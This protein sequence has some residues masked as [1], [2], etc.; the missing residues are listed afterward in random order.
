MGTS[1]TQTALAK[2]EE[3][4]ILKR[5]ITE[6]QWSTLCNSLFPGAK[7]SS[8]L[9]VWDYCRARNLDPMKKPCHIVPMKVKDS[10]TGQYDW[11]DVILPG[12]YEHRATAH[13]TG[14]YLGHTKPE[15][16]EMED[17]GE[18]V[19]APTWCE[20]TFY[21]HMKHGR[22]EFPVRVFFAEVVGYNKEGKPNDRWSR[23]PI[24]MLTKCCEAAGLREAFPEE[25]GGEQTAEEIEGQRALDQPCETILPKNGTI[26]LESLAPSESE[27]R[28]HDATQVPPGP[29]A[30]GGE[31]VPPSGDSLT[32][33]KF[34]AATGR[35]DVVIDGSSDLRPTISS[36]GTG[37]DGS[38]GPSALATA[39]QAT[40][41]QSS[42]DKQ[43]PSG[44][45]PTVPA[46]KHSTQI[47]AAVQ[48]AVAKVHK[49]L[50]FHYLNDVWILSG[51]HCIEGF[52]LNPDT[53]KA[54]AA[55]NPDI[56]CFLEILL[57]LGKH[58]TLKLS[59]WLLE[60]NLRWS[61]F[62]AY[63]QKD[64]K[65]LTPKY[66]GAQTVAAIATGNRASILNAITPSEQ[67]LEEVKELF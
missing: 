65:E 38:I 2:K 59:Q 21:R 20:M 12:V 25:I 11:R 16:G 22:A 3:N 49:A 37:E 55:S 14:E 52:D 63:L 9:L 57:L 34:S 31:G 50:N 5:G 47:P 7:P 53:A 36:G 26:T 67:T 44:G 1:D 24:Q 28:G 43:T 42:P 66:V 27:N 64:K 32:P 4:P 62:Y 15:Y 54:A 40:S 30:T 45:L 46:A 48:A 6:A 18:G 19:M 60:Q 39:I 13:R 61:E 29:L 33:S 41:S 23:A 56:G 8:V 17:F 51:R 58:D 10:K 35:R